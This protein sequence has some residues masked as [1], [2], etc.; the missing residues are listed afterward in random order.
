LAERKGD[1]GDDRNDENAN[2]AGRQCPLK[3]HLNCSVPCDTDSIFFGLID[4]TRS[5]L[6]RARKIELAR[7]SHCRSCPLAWCSSVR[8]TASLG[9]VG[10]MTT[11]GN[12]TTGSSLKVAM[13][14]RVM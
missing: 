5:L 11:A 3:F 14:S 8:A 4:L 6:A 2:A 13:V 10:Q 1:H 12:P 9:R 7:I